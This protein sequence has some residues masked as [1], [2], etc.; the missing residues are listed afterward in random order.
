M[1]A[2]IACLVFTAAVAGRLAAAYHTVDNGSGAAD[3]LVYL[4]RTE[5]AIATQA[6]IPCTGPRPELPPLFS[7]AKLHADNL[8]AI[9]QP[10]H[11]S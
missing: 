6:R 2:T 1:S 5:G 7:R 4:K 9:P 3:A 8:N 10:T 11:R